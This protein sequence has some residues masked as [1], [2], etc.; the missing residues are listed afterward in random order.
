VAESGLPALDRKQRDGFHPPPARLHGNARL[1]T[2]AFLTQA[3]SSDGQGAAVWTDE[4]QPHT[5][6]VTGRKAL[7]V[8]L[9]QPDDFQGNAVARPCAHRQQSTAAMWIAQNDTWPVSEL[10]GNEMRWYPIATYARRGARRTAK[11][12]AGMLLAML[13][14]QDR[15]LQVVE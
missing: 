8:R 15:Q 10:N 7:L 13:G 12:L 4:S 5:A 6:I 14:E 11:G 2:S 1:E 3:C 9:V